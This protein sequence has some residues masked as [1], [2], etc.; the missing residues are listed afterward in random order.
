MNQ[1]DQDRSAARLAPPGG[2]EIGVGFEKYRHRAGRHEPAE[3]AGLDDFASAAA[4][5]VMPAMV[6]DQ[7]RHPRARLGVD[8]SLRSGHGVGHWLLDQGGNTALNAV[9]GHSNMGLVGRGHHCAAG[10][11]AL[12]H[13]A[14]VRIPGHAQALR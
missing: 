8:Q 3:P 11:H 10:L 13:V 6:A 12:E 5:G 4:D 14:V 7:H 9:D 2:F 1:V